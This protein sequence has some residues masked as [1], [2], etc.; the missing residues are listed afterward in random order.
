MS[1]FWIQALVYLDTHWKWKNLQL[2]LGCLLEI[3]IHFITPDPLCTYEFSRHLLYWSRRADQ[4]AINFN[5]L[6]NNSTFD[7]VDGIFNIYQK[8]QDKDIIQDA[9]VNTSHL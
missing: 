9:I 3:D 7:F 2:H 5:K 4:V 8:T 6:T 1:H